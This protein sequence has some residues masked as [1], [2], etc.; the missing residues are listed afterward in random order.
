VVQAHVGQLDAGQQ[1]P[2]LVRR[3]RLPGGGAPPHRQL[4]LRTHTVV[5]MKDQTSMASR[6]LDIQESTNVISRLVYPRHA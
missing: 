1:R 4:P 5:Y 3:L 6:L 2:V